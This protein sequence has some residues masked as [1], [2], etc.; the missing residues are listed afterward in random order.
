MAGRPT[1]IVENRFGVFRTRIRSGVERGLERQGQR[2][3]SAIRSEAPVG[4]GSSGVTAGHMR[5]TLKLSPVTSTRR[6]KEIAVYS[7]DPTVLWQDKGTLGRRRTK[8]K[9][10]SLK[11]R[12]ERAQAIAA[13][14]GGVKPKRFFGKG[15]R[16]AQG[17]RGT[18]DAIAAELRGLR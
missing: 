17:A 12:K 4:D 1:M 3:L 13:A 6:G 14:G 11:R 2:V 7:D 16:A 5:D 10:R 9:P 15:L 18:L 8:L